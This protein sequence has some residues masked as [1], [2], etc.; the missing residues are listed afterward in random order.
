[1][2]RSV[3]VLLFAALFLSAGSLPAQ[4]GT[5]G[6]ILGVVT[7]TTGAVVPGAEVVI[8]NVETGQSVT[9]GSN[10]VGI[11]EVFAL[12]R[13]F[14]DITVT[15]DGFKTWSMERAELTLGERL[16]ITPAL[17]VGDAIEVTD[18]DAHAGLFGAGGIQ[19]HAGEE[20]FFRERSVLLVRK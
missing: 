4:L 12:N 3:S 11:F 6:S 2:K 7:D 10:E 17:E 15:L 20:A 9:T 18:G 16:R 13:G 14:Y 5:Q 1:M 19:G 8:T